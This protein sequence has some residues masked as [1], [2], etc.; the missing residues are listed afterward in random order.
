MTNWVQFEDSFV[1]VFSML[2]K[3]DRVEQENKF[4]QPSWA[5]NPSTGMEQSLE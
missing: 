5:W 2:G 1:E 3:M 4:L